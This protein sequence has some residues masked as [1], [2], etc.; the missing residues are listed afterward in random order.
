MITVYVDGACKGNPGPGGWG[1][2]VKDEKGKAYALKGH[3]SNTTN[4][5]MEIMAAVE[6]LKFCNEKFPSIPI[7]IYTDS[8]YLCDGISYWIRAWAINGWRTT[9]GRAVRN[10]DLWKELSA[11][12]YGKIIE[13]AWVKSHSGNEGNEI[14]DKLANQAIDEG[15]EV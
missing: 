7:K 6:A 13:W 9:Q 4:N 15:C 12:R 2:Y 8:K 10:K 1:A 14:A 11:A 5:R 3:E